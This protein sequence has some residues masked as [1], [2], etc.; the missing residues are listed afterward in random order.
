MRYCISVIALLYMALS[1][2]SQQIIWSNDFSNCNSWVIQNAN[3]DLGLTN[4]ISGINFQCG[5][6]GPSGPVAIAPI[7]STTAANGFMLL[8]SD[9][10]G[11]STPGIWEENCWFQ[12]AQP[13]N[14]TGYDELSLQFQTYY[15]MW[16]NGSSDG[17]EYCLVE[18]STD[19][20][21]WPDVTTYEVNDAAPG[22]RFEL[23]PTMGTQDPVANPTVKTFNISQVASQSGV[24][25]IWLRFRWKGYWGYAWMIDD[26][27]VY[28]TPANDLWL[29][30]AWVN[31]ILTGYEYYAIP[32]SEASVASVTMGAAIQNI[33]SQTQTAILNVNIDGTNHQVSAPIL[34]G[35]I[36]TLWV[37][38]FFLP[39]T[40]GE[41]NVTFSIPT[42]ANSSDNFA[43]KTIEITDYIYGQNSN[44]NLVQR[45]LN[46]D[47]EIA[48]GCAYSINTFNTCYGIQTLFGEGTDIGVECYAVL[49][50]VLSSVQDLAYQ[51][52]S[53]PI[54]VTQELINQS[55]QGN[56]VTLPL[57]MPVPLFP[58]R[59]YVA[60]IRR[61]PSFE[62]IYIL[63]NLED[64]DF[65]T[66][67]Y[68]PFGSGGIENWFVGWSFTPAV[69]MV[70]GEDAFL[71]CTQPNACNYNE[72][73]NF[74]DGS[75][76]TPG[77]S[78]DDGNSLTYN[79]LFNEN[80]ECAGE[81]IVSPEEC[82]GESIYFTSVNFPS[83]VI[84]GEGELYNYYTTLNEPTA[85]SI[86]LYMP[87]SVLSGFAP[88]TE[89]QYYSP[90]TGGYE[91]ISNLGLNFNCSY[92]DCAFSF[93]DDYGHLCFQLSGLPNQVGSFPIR[94]LFES[95]P[96]VIYMNQIVLHI[97]T[98]CT[99]PNACNFGEPNFCSYLQP[100]SIIGNPNITPFNTYSYV[101][102]QG[103]Y[104]I[105]WSAQNGT[106][107]TGQNTNAAQI[108]WLENGPYTV[109]A[110]ISDALGCVQTSTFI[111][112]NNSCNIT[113]SI[114]T[115]ENSICPGESA[116][117]SAVTATPNVSYQWLLNGQ[118]ITN[119]TANNYTATTQG[120]YQVIISIPGCSAISNTIQ[121]DAVAVASEPVIDY[122]LSNPGCGDGVAIL[123]FNS[124]DFNSFQW[125][126]GQTSPT[127][128]VTTS[129]AYSV[130][131][132][133]AS[134]CVV[135]SEVVP[136]NFA[137][138]EPNHICLVTVDPTTGNNTIVWEP[139]TSE[140]I[141]DYL[142]YKET[143]VANEYAL[144]GSVDYGSDGIFTDENSNSA[145][146]ASRY[147][148]GVMDICNVESTLSSLHKTIHLTSNL[149]V[150]NTVNLIWSHYEGAE[151][152]SYNIYRGTAADNLTL[153]TTIASNLNSYTDLLP[154]T[155]GF[156]MIEVEGISCDPSREVLT[157]TSNIITIA[158]VGINES[159]AASIR[160]YPN[161]AREYITLEIPHELV[162]ETMV[163]YDVTGREIYRS[164]TANTTNII[165]VAIFSSGS[166][167]LRVGNQNVRF[168][169]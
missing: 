66:V 108:M 127:I 12:T 55:A 165:N 126:T 130:S 132:V 158:E 36:D 45:T 53:N 73:A 114:S 85:L 65:G 145:V 159:V 13:I 151:F 147:K 75:C 166:Y 103:D 97:N 72:F 112:T 5:T 121:I 122:L 125:S 124:D 161:P 118:E 58:G 77:S 91:P 131:A 9:A 152:G 137:L 60:E 92:A 78:C 18:I 134:G 162:G 29:Q 69:R 129:G 30:K 110:T 104:S 7:N 160:A 142:I 1:T 168:E 105:V 116:Q 148:I 93:N 56:Y 49:Y 35:D 74:D 3:D 20:V 39:Q 14:I 48:I 52:Q 2:Y 4:Y 8:D 21:T 79:D 32:S 31:N 40:L 117:L 63:S 67:C 42:D 167:V 6:E 138:I 34:P 113:V 88:L 37:P 80:C 98:T 25:Q 115:S 57:T 10:F 62:R 133:D 87:S 95:A 135:T 146:Q 26:V 143:N 164:N 76:E 47:A 163:I 136:I 38:A 141:T 68:G 46:N 43:Y 156:Y 96:I 50:E 149:G 22:T 51:G 33:G 106:I 44:E 16:D 82:E 157:S 24:N 54:V 86:N 140:F 59:N 154:I 83:Q 101:I 111:A 169:R 153:L 61:G 71:G 128:S 139:V 90:T 81:A 84:A 94:L 41:Y 99:D 15:R 155:D 70:L 89:I 123:S 28:Q 144:I 102:P 27:K 23:W 107:I 119:A 150:G 19:G 11:G 120:A 109:S 100:Q 17:N 64:D